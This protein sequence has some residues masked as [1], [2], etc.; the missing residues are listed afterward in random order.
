MD[1]RSFLSGSLKYA[2][3]GAGFSPSRRTVMID[4][5]VHVWKHTPEFPF[6]EGAKPPDFDITAEDLLKLMDSHGVARTVLIQVSHYR[7]DNRYLLDVLHRH[8]GKFHGVCRVNPED[9]AA[10]DHLST[11]TESGCHGVR[12]SPD[13][14]VK[15]DWIRGPLMAPLWRRCAQLKVPM[16]LLL[17]ASRLPDVAPWIEKNPDLTVVIDHMA[18]IPAGDRQQLQLLLAMARYPRVY[19]KISHMWSLSQKPFPYPDLTDQLLRLRDAFGANRLM[20]GT[21]WPILRERLSYDQRVALYRD[22]LGFLSNPEREEI[23]YRTV[24]R[25]WPFGL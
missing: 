8:P 9:P 22:H 5:H 7:W 2:L 6:A 1:R 12:L 18:D 23:L 24:Q 16:T 20:W 10:P 3:V 13:A 11:L 21:D 25:V 19:V 15:G 14:T 4:S 17:P